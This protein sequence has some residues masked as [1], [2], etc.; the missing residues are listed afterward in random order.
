MKALSKSEFIRVFIS[1]HL[2]GRHTRREYVSMVTYVA[3][4]VKAIVLL[5]VSSRCWHLLRVGSWRRPAA[6][7]HLNWCTALTI[8]PRLRTLSISSSFTRSARRCGGKASGRLGHGLG[9]VRCRRPRCSGPLRRLDQR[10]TSSYPDGVPRIAACP[11]GR[12]TSVCAG[13]ASGLDGG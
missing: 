7:P 12:L 4:R 2:S 9:A 3:T 13:S 1:F 8:S 6:S 5:E 10:A 11:A